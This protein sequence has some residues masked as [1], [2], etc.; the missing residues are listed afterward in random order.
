MEIIV[1]AAGLSSRFPDMRPKFT[2]TDHNGDM[3]LLNA[4]RSFLGKNRVWVGILQDHEERFQLTKMLNHQFGDQV[5]S[6]VLT[7]RQKGPAYTANEIINEAKLSKDSPI[8]IKDCDSFFDFQDNA[9][10]YICVSKFSDNENVRN[11]S[12]KSYIISNINGIVTSVIE[13]EVISDKF[14]VGGYKFESVQQFQDNY[15]EI[16]KLDCEIYVSHVIQRSISNGTVFLENIVSNYVD[17][18]DAKSWFDFNNKFT[19]FVDIDGTTVKAQPK[20][21]YDQDPIPLVENVNALL[22]KM[23]EGNEIVFVTSR[24]ENSRQDTERALKLL[25][26]TNYRLI[27]GLKNST[28]VLINDFNEANPY[29]RAVA[30]NVH[31]DSDSLKYLI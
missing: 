3:M 12:K 27:M 25:G 23:Q 1:P 17:V 4:I 18:G 9:P 20:H 21:E 13:K 8:L 6:I 30:V 26:F 16:Q 19:Y 31:R 29:P 22:K 15:N 7:G 24:K 14:C 2:L 11:P 5:S 28:R 10:N